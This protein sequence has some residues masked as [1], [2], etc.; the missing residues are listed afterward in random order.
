MPPIRVLNA[1]DTETMR[2]AIVRVLKENPDYEA[3]REAANFAQVIY[4]AGSKPGSAESDYPVS[5]MRLVLRTEL[6]V[7]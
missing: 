6:L 3:V 7:R 2:S 5:A 1:D 4:P